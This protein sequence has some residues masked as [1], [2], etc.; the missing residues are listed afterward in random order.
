[1]EVGELRLEIGGLDRD[2]VRALLAEHLVEMRATSPAESVHALPLEALRA[3]DITLWTAR[4]GDVLVGCGA[5]KDLGDG[6]VEIKSMRTAVAARGRGVGRRLLRHLLE[7]ARRRGGTRV[8]LETGTQDHFAAA[9]R[10]YE[11]HGFVPVA[12]FGSY[13][14]DPSSAFYSREL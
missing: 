11:R 3:E 14:L 5:L 8:S 7:E 12:P 10:L 6:H 2:D 13:V 9:R 4:A 1:M